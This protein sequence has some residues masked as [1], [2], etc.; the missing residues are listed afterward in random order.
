MRYMRSES[1]Y[2]NGYCGN[3][4]RPTLDRSTAPD[5]QSPPFHSPFDSSKLILYDWSNKWLT[6]EEYH[7]ILS[8]NELYSTSCSIQRYPPKTHPPTT[9]TDPTS[10]EEVR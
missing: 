1:P 8:N 3:D 5:A 7:N 9:Y 4:A 10:K 2:E 6:G